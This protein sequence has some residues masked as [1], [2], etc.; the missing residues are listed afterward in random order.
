M[1]Q[2]KLIKFNS[3]IQSILKEKDMDY[4]DAIL[5]WCDKNDVDIDLAASLVKQDANLVHQVQIDAESLNYV[6]KTAR[7]T[8]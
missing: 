4:I 2:E 8:I 6:K 5:Y 3:D 7:L 1:I